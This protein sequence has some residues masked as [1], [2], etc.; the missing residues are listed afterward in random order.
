M[1]RHRFFA[2]PSS[3]TE[4]AIALDEDESN[5]L[6]RVL[7]LKEGDVVSVVD[8]LGSE[9]ECEVQDRQGSQAILA[10]KAKTQPDV[11][12]PLKVTLAQ[13]LAKGEKF[14]FII[15]KA[16]ELGAAGFVPLITRY[17]EKMAEHFQAR[18]RMDRWR[19]ISLSAVKQSGRT[20][21]MQ[22]AEPVRFKEFVQTLS[23]RAVV[24]T[25]RQG[26]TLREIEQKWSVD[27]PEVVTVLVGPE[28]GWSR[29]EIEATVGRGALPVSLGPRILRTETAGL[30]IIS[31]LQYLFGDL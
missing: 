7:R 12:S 9:Y 17:T 4:S 27:S 29:E 15:Q 10:I 31:V 20:K 30:V 6:R 22:I 14:D 1:S 24:C 8:G 26:I 2:A 18:T 23:G 11:E 3:I 16:T 21:L 5:H 19:R 13:A 28:G 25:E